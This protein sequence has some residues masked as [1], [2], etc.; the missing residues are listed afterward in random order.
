VTFGISR[1]A[2]SPQVIGIGLKFF[3]LIQLIYMVPLYLFLRRQQRYAATGL[4]TAACFIGLISISCA[5]T[6]R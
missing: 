2:N 6:M 1:A 3:G 4:A 5:T